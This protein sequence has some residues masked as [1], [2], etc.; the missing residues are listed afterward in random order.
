MKSFR[1][2]IKYYFGSSYRRQNLDKLLKKYQEEYIGKVLDIGGRDRGNFNKPKTETEQWIFADIEPGYKPD[3]MIDVT[4]M[5]TIDSESFNVVNAI[6]L[7]EHVD[8]VEKGISECYRVLKKDGT[9]ILSAPFLFRIHSDPYDF[10][11]WTESKWKNELSKSGFNIRTFV[12]VGRYY[13]VSNEMKKTFIQSLPVI[14]RHIGYIIFPLLDI[15]NLLDQT[16][17]IMNHKKLGNFHG[18]YFIIAKK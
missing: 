5:K 1:D 6:E 15:I 3:I 4:D 11:R 2:N 12:I 14:L 7:F 8:S 9:L 16:K 10:Q 13:T 17:W 18:G